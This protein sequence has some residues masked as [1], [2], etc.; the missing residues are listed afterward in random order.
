[1]SKLRLRD[2]QGP[3]MHPLQNSA[4]GDVAIEISNLSYV[5]PG[6]AVPSLN[7]VSL[8]IPRGH[9]FGLLGTNGA[10]KT[11]II[12]ILTGMLRVQ[13]GTVTVTTGCSSSSHDDIKRIS[14]IVPQDL[15]FYPGLTGYENL[16]CFAGLQGLSGK[17]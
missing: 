8:S 16:S 1:L 11:T 4:H 12:S 9:C 7:Q 5:Y 2:V 10:G 6:N 14:A 17:Q 13:T 3:Y 15:A